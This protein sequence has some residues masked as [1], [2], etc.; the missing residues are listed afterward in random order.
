MVACSASRSRSRMDVSKRDSARTGFDDDA[1]ARAEATAAPKS[2]GE[3][4]S[5]GD[6]GM[7]SR[8]NGTAVFVVKPGEVKTRRRAANSFEGEES[9]PTWCAATRTHPENL[10]ESAASA[11]APSPLLR[12]ERVGDD[13]TAKLLT[14]WPS[15]A[16]FKAFHGLVNVY[17]VLEESPVF[18]A[19]A[20]E[21]AVEAA[22]EAP[23]LRADG[24]LPHADD[25]RL[26]ADPRGGAGGRPRMLDSTNMLFLCFKRLILFVL[27]DP[28]LSHLR[29][30][31]L[32]TQTASL[33]GD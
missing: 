26:P 18:R 27:G 12:F 3:G 9:R 32:I 4:T 14:G 22:G 15:V 19:A 8:E 29:R 2:I 7:A 24:S 23:G 33:A 31:R 25:L 6:G 5:G 17:G 30:D 20:V 11:R 13:N 21:Q 28:G 1:A 16:A 10:E